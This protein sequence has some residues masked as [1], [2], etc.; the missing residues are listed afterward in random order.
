MNDLLNIENFLGYVANNNP[1]RASRDGKYW[2]SMIPAPTW[3]EMISKR[4]GSVKDTV[5]EMR[6]LIESNYWQASKVAKELKRN[7]LY[8]TCRE[9][10]EWLFY[11]IRYNED[12]PGKEELRTFSRTFAERKT[13]VD[14]DDFSIAAGSLLKC[15]NIP[16]YIRIARYQGKDYFQH[17]YVVV[18]VSKT[19]YITIDGV[20]DD[21]DAEKP[22][23][24]TKDFIVMNNSS[25]NGVDIS[26]LGGADD[27]LFNELSGI[28]YGTDF[29]G[30]EEIEGLGNPDDMEQAVLGAIKNYLVRTRNFV[31]R[32]PQMVADV[33]SPAAFLGM[34]DYAI[35]YW[36]TDLRDDALGVL[37]NEES[38]IN[39][40]NGLGN[41]IDTFEGV[42]LFYGL[43]DNGT[44]DLLGKAKAPKKFFTA[45]KKATQNVKQA[46][47]KTTQKVAQKTQQVAKKAVTVA[48]KIAKPLIRYNPAVAGIRAAVLL[49]LKVNLLKSASKLKWGYLTQ[50]EA[51]SRGFDMVEWMKIKTQLAKAENMFVN[52]LQGKAENFKNA[53]INGRAGGLSGED[54]GLGVVVATATAATTAAATPFITK[55]LNLLKN[56][57]F[58][59]LVKGVKA[60]NLK[61]KPKAAEQDLVTPEGGSAMPEGGQA[62]DTPPSES[63]PTETSETSD[64]PEQET[65]VQE[66]QSSSS[67]S[68]STIETGN[69]DA[70]KI[71]TQSDGDKTIITSNPSGGSN[72]SNTESE[73]GSTDSSNPDNLPANTGARGPAP[74]TNEGGS[75]ENFF[76]KAVTWVKENPTTSILVAGGTAF[77]VTMALSGDKKNTPVLSGTKKRGKLRKGKKKK[78]PPR[79]ITGVPKPKHKKRNK[80]RNKVKN[81]K[82]K[83]HRPKER[84]KHKHKRPTKKF[85]L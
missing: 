42:D 41:V 59:K 67:S 47:R 27:E 85:R 73:E 81:R 70:N 17:V 62:S 40:M 50:A 13:G 32:R 4:N 8:E 80:K 53:I 28:L 74:S 46:V 14:C 52:E 12:S 56:I 6:K 54:L 66:N 20:L 1:L 24:E 58:E 23:V 71:T 35:K 10:W 76:T 60:L 2:E 72:T 83:H 9:I 75:T 31:A 38:R 19:E 51:Q 22:P 45:V 65:P 15:L 44:Y 25:L 49:A 33:Q 57:N 68:D 48:K 36:D 61:R 84:I 5:G 34:L 18:P 7:T 30:F 63:Q 16:F 11:H 55:I 29:D 82:R 37:E 43:T 77:L 21:Y 64:T 69:N 78:N 3:S 79:V 26:V 39:E